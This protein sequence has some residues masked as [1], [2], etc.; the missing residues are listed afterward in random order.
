MRAFQ[1]SLSLW[2]EENPTVW[3]TG[4]RSRYMKLCKWRELRHT[5]AVLSQV[6]SFIRL[7]Y[8]LNTAE[9]TLI[10]IWTCANFSIQFWAIGLFTRSMWSCVK[11]NSSL[12][13]LAQG[14]CRL[15]RCKYRSPESKRRE[16]Y[17]MCHELI[18]WWSG[19]LKSSHQ[20]LLY[21]FVWMRKKNTIARWCR[22]PRRLSCDRE[23][24]SFGKKRTCH[25]AN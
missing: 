18:N 20:H 6:N 16:A 23:K 21:M 14:W 9:Y 15:Q 5:L 8:R 11:G 1:F 19:D 10:F 17:Y 3:I 7:F 12:C 2:M 4:L 13:M 24:P 25:N 22:R